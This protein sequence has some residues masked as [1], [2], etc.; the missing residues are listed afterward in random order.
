MTTLRELCVAVRMR[1]DVPNE[2]ASDE[3]VEHMVRAATGEQWK[4]SRAYEDQVVELVA[5]RLREVVAGP[6]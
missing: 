6:K 3:Y 1:A 5:K 2:W 4:L